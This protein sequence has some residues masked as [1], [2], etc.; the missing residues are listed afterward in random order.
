METLAGYL[1]PVLQ[2]SQ[3]SYW[4]PCWHGAVDGWDVA[5]NFH[6]QCDGK[7]PTVT[8]VRVG[9][10]IFGGYADKPWNS[11]GNSFYD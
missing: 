3:T 4:T 9:P 7:G 10:H 8:I 2:S 6:G 11:N 1:A 5:V